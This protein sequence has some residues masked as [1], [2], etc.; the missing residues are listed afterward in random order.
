MKLVHFEPTRMSHPREE[1]IEFVKRIA[2]GTEP[3]KGPE[4]RSEPRWRV[5]MPVPVAHLDE[6]LCPCGP[7]FIA[8]S[9]DISTQGMG[10]YH[11][12]PIEVKSLLGVE[13]RAPQGDTM[14]AVLEVVRCQL[15]GPAFEIG[16]RFMA[17]VYENGQR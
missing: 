16:G 12:R 1:L 5:T 10:L 11:T 6:H 17:K 3:Y 2:A 7:T 14:Q 15:N 13:L 9:R 4:R 8:I